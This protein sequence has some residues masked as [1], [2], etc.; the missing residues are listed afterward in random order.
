MSIHPDFEASSGYINRVDYRTIG[1]Y[2]NARIYPEKKYLSQV[3]LYLSAGQRYGYIEDTLQ[4]QWVRTQLGFRITE[5]SQVYFSHANRLERY[6]DVDFWRNTFS[7]EGQLL[8]ISWLPLAFF[9]ETGDS[10]YYDP[11]DPFLGYSNIYGV[12]V[13]IK[14]SKRLR[15]GV[16]FTKQTFWEQRGGDQV[17]DFNVV[18][19]R[20]TYQISKTLSL[21]AIVD[22]NHYYKEIYGSFL[23]SYML[24]PGTVFF[25][26]VDNNLLENA[27]GHY[28]SDSYSIF[29]KFSYWFRI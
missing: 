16:D 15:V 7:L 26:G 14:P 22:Y 24:R 11:D 20:T 12:G 13:T 6:A 18:R 8:L 29:I 17:Y 25:F 4:D 21:R 1:A 10:I 3:G 28:N 9:F 19:T 5:F 27:Q 23:F 2:A